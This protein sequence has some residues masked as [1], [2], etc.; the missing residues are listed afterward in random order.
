MVEKVAVIARFHA[1]GVT[2]QKIDSAAVG[3]FL[4]VEHVEAGAFSR[5]IRPDQR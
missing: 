4:A 3:N 5:A 2:S 1:S